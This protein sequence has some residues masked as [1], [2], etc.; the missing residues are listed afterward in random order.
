MLVDMAFQDPRINCRNVNLRTVS[1][2]LVGKTR[3]RICF[4]IA[5]IRPEYRFV[6]QEDPLILLCKEKVNSPQP[7]M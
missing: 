4:K 1:V 7:W 6:L 5:R 2:Q 3:L